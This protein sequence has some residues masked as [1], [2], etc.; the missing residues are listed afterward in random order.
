LKTAYISIGSNLG[1]RL[2]YLKKA[3]WL[4]QAREEIQLTQLSSCYET[5][6]LGYVKQG[7]F[8]NAVFSLQTSCT[9][10]ALLKILQGIE[11][12]LGRERTVRW[13]PR[14]VDLDILFYA[15]TVLQDSVLTIPHPRLTERAFV[16]VPL[17]E[18]APLLLH[19]LTGKTIRQHLEEVEG[20]SGVVK[21][22]L[23]KLRGG[24]HE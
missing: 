19:P 21:L 5:E 23:D 24:R 17:A 13:G 1:D 4:L 9:P 11:S 12:F 6:P 20:R 16:L 18:I 2:G 22:E 7:K 8:I 10:H 3:W 15:D 14:S